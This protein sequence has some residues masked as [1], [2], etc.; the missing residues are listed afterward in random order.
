MKRERSPN[1]ATTHWRAEAFF[2]YFILFF[3]DKAGGHL[4]SCKH[5]L[6]CRASSTKRETLLSFCT[7]KAAIWERGHG[8]HL[9]GDGKKKKNS[10]GG[11][12]TFCLFTFK[13]G[14][15]GVFFPVKPAGNSIRAYWC[16]APHSTCVTVTRETR[17]SAVL[18]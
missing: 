16:E 5:T 12:E 17:R 18:N 9:D 8:K 13:T 1:F 2:F 6:H 7:Q 15:S 11:N 3:S 14:Q 10:K 4:K